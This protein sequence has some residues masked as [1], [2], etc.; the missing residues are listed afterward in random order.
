[1]YCI[2]GL[3]YFDLKLH[4]GLL[5]DPST[6]R[7]TPRWLKVLIPIVGA[8][9]LVGILLATPYREI[10]DY[11]YR[12]EEEQKG[13]SRPLRGASCFSGGQRI[14]RSGSDGP[15]Q[16]R[17]LGAWRSYLEGGGSLCGGKSGKENRDSLQGTRSAAASPRWTRTWKS[18][19]PWD[20]IRLLRIEANDCRVEVTLPENLPDQVRIEID[21]EDGAI[22]LSSS[23][24]SLG[25]ND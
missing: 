22:R 9:L 19:L 1:M 18:H 15:G 5:L 17:G 12:A 4:R 8:G 13:R 20:R 16:G 11:E 10:R 23:P 25:W 24:D 6:T 7:E 3:L 14:G 21:G 2:A